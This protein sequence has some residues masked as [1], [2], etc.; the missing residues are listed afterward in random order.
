MSKKYY[1]NQ[2]YYNDS[3]YKSKYKAIIEHNELVETDIIFEPPKKNE[4]VD[5]LEVCSGVGLFCAEVIHDD[6]ALVK[7]YIYKS[8]MYSTANKEELDKFNNFQKEQMGISRDNIEEGYEDVCNSHPSSNNLSF[9]KEKHQDEKSHDGKD[10]DCKDKDGKDKECKE[11]NNYVAIDGV[12][13]HTTLSIPFEAYIYIHGVTT[14]DEL[15][16]ELEFV[17]NSDGKDII[18]EGGKI[19]GLKETDVVKVSVTVDKHNH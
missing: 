3:Y 13:R 7:G 1:K 19:K 11:R 17:R 12:I 8:I 6:L 10:K 14:N 15:I 4:V 18:M 9:K 16:A 5:V 2:S